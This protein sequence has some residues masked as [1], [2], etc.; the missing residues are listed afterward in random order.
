METK[1]C[2]ETIRNG[3]LD[4]INSKFAVGFD[5]MIV[6]FISVETDEETGDHKIQ[7]AIFQKYFS[8]IFWKLLKFQ[9]ISILCR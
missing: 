1:N 4:S 5:D 9:L 8:K 6:E 3:I 2:A 7:R